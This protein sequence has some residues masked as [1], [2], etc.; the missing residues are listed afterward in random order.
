MPP[1]GT[2]Q[3]SKRDLKLPHGVSVSVD[4]PYTEGHILTALEAEKLNHAKAASAE[5]QSFAD[6]YEFAVRTPKASA[7][8]IAKEANKIAKEQVFAAIRRKG[9]NPSDYSAEQIAEYV[10]KVLQHKPEIRAE[11]QRRIESS[12]KMAGDLLSDLFDEAA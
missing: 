7:D 2:N 8:P 6:A 10:G 12:R 11:A 3:M 9:G 4:Q 5:F 1:K